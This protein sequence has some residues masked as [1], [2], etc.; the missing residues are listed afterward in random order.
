LESQKEKEGKMLLGVKKQGALSALSSPKMLC[1][2][3]EDIKFSGVFI[4]HDNRPSHGQT[5][6]ADSPSLIR[7]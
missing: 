5:I 1:N 6:H 4:S 2:T 7:Y 3:P